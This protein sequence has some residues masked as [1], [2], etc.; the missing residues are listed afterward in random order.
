MNKRLNIFL[1][2]YAVMVVLFFINK[3]L[4]VQDNYQYEGVVASISS[5]YVG[6]DGNDGKSYYPY[7]EYYKEKDTLTVSDKGWTTIFLDT[8]DNV[9][10]IVDKEDKSVIKLKTLFNYWIPVHAII[11]FIFLLCVGIGVEQTYFSR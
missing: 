4:Y 11:I 9:T 1:W 10:V 3:W 5:I 8:G 2:F 7:V 6:Y